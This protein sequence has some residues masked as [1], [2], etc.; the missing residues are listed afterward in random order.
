MKKSVPVPQT[1]PT[2]RVNNAGRNRFQGENTVPLYEW[3]FPRGTRLTGENFP[4]PKM[5]F[6][7]VTR[8]ID[9]IPL[10]TPFFEDSYIHQYGHTVG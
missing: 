6:A 5:A 3:F 9:R 2:G 1:H 10:F 7:A 4:D 8:R